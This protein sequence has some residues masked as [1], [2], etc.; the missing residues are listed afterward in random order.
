MHTLR[1]L[2]VLVIAALGAN[3]ATAGE[4]ALHTEPTSMSGGIACETLEQVRLAIV[5]LHDQSLAYPEG[6][7]LIKRNSP[8][9][10]IAYLVG[11]D[12]ANDSRVFHLSRYEF[13]HAVSGGSFLPFV[14]EAGEEVTITRYG[15]WGTEPLATEGE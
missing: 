2:A 14:V 11:E 4:T 7:I 10:G 1:I 9:L 3:S 15:W 13:T 12:Y 5:E 8:A 6:C